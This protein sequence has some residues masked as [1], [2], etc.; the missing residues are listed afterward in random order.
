MVT[1]GERML[2]HAGAPSLL[3]ESFCNSRALAVHMHTSGTLKACFGDWAFIKVL[4]TEILGF[5]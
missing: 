5:Y 3:G 1:L 4:G 2:E